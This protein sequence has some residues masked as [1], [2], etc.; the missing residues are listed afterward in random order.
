MAPTAGILLGLLAGLVAGSFIGVLTLRWPAGQGLGG[1]S[2]CDAC[3]A[4]LG[5]LDLVPL[6]SFALLRGRCRHCGQPIAP[7]HIALELAGGAIGALALALMPGW[8]GVA[9]AGL[10]W[11]LLALLVLDVE[12]YWLP[13]R[14][15]LPLG[16]AGLLAGLWLA[17]SLPLRLAGAVAGF[18]LLWLLAAGYR[19]VRGVDGMGG[20]DPKLLAAIGAWLGPWVLPLV[21]AAAA[22][23]GLLLVGL[24]RLHG[25]PVS[26]ATRVPLGALLAG[27]GWLAWA[28]SPWLAAKGLM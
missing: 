22:G 12:H 19:R 13:D 2:A 10:G 3:G 24:D 1:R 14:L 23:L 27:A 4:T 18:L 11:A 9:G 28:A 8:A 21:M 17:P 5:P 16:A 15:T 20:G 6:L 25:R 26:L 7:R